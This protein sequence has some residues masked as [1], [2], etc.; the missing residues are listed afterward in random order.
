MLNNN[1]KIDWYQKLSTIKQKPKI[2][3]E[4]SRMELGKHKDFRRK[5]LVKS[6]NALEQ[7]IYGNFADSEGGLVSLQ[8]QN[9][10]TGVDVEIRR[11]FLYVMA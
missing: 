7:T 6:L 3:S 2:W 1:N 11:S 5:L 8:W 9:T 10:N 4:F